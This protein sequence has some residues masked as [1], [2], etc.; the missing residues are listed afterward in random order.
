MRGGSHVVVA[1]VD[2][3]SWCRSWCGWGKVKVRASQAKMRL[4]M[5][6]P[7]QEEKRQSEVL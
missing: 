1:Q 5:T 7:G 6:C 3:C 4:T 2:C